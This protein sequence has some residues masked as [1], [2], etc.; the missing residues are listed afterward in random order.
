TP[1][2]EVATPEQ[3]QGD[4]E[5]GEENL[6]GGYDD[7]AHRTRTAPDDGTDRAQTAEDPIRGTMKV[8]SQARASS[9]VRPMTGAETASAATRGTGKLEGF[10]A[11]RRARM[12]DELIPER[13]R[14]GRVLDIGHGS[15]PSFLIQT[16]FRERHGIDRLSEEAR[17]RWE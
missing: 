12:A 10:L 17:R 14:E 13:C 1:A 2:H 4:A 15:T 9:T 7:G 8:C 11:G 16:R 3:N 6:E 5:P